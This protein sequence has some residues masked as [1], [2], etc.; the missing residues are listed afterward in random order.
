MLSLN[1]NYLDTD[2]YI[3]NTSGGEEW[4]KVVGK[5]A[6]HAELRPQEILQPEYFYNFL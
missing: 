4:S 5:A 6:Q 3:S 1:I 2:E